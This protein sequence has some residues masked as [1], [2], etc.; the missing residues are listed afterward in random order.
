M[1][2]EEAVK[3]WQEHIQPKKDLGYKLVSP[4]T[5]SNP[6]GKEWMQKFYD[7]CQG[8]TFDAQAVHWYDIHAQ[9]F[10]DYV[11]DYHD[12]FGYPVFITEFADQNF[13]GG[14]QASMD[15]IWAFKAAVTPFLENTDWVLG[16]FPFGE[17]PASLSSRSR[18]DTSPKAS[19]TIWSMSTT[20][21][22][23]WVATGSPPRSA[24]RTSTN[25]LPGPRCIPIRAWEHIPHV[26]L[27]RPSSLAV[28]AAV[29]AL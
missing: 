23:S 22:S 25:R 24:P 8:C 5:S 28:G 7:Q 21:T 10:I 11:S 29:M 19:C 15:D 16:Y 12:R 18:T 3:L 27:P 9:D 14:A 26:A 6:A 20:T 1:S 2:P 17:L 4:A 13:N